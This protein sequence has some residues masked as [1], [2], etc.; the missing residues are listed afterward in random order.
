MLGELYIGGVGLA[1]GYLQQPELTA[2]RFVPHP[3]SEV[4]GARLYMTG[5]LVRCR[6]DGVLEFLGRLDQQVKVRGYRIELGEIEA[7]L[8]QHP[9][10][11]EAVVLAR[12]GTAD[13]TR[14]IAY[15]VA[16]Q[17]P[18]HG[19]GALRRFVQG[20]LP[21]FMIPSTFV[22][23]ERLPRTPN[24]KVDRQALPTPPQDRPQLE[25]ALV[26]PRTPVEEA[27]AGVWAEILRLPQVGVH[28]N[29]FALGGHSLLATQV[30]ARLK[31]AFQ[32]EVPLRCLFEAP[33]VAALAQTIAA[34]ESRPGQT[35]QIARLLKRIE[36]MSAEA[37]A[38]VLA[39]AREE[40]D[41]R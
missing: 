25:E 7:V 26:T 31:A 11:Q 36:G 19:I 9:A 12:E 8:T 40:K 10:V 16:N 23:L 41:Q 3:F 20:V 4:P 13:D 2:E 1:R 27:L 14:L 37:R 5:D 32:V 38:I 35:E 28:D 6:A 17:S 30:I 21:D 22:L 29:F 33:T 15:V 39:K 24:G 18:D 34:Y